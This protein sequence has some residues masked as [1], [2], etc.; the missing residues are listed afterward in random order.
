MEP[1]E[2]V[3]C[4]DDLGYS[5]ARDAG[6][7]RCAEQGL[8]TTASL[9]VT[10]ASARSAAARALRMGLPLGLHLNLTEGCP[11]SRADEVR[12]LL[13]PHHGAASCSDEPPRCA[14]PEL[15]GHGASQR[16]HLVFRGKHGARDAAAAGLLVGAEIERE[17][18]AQIAAFV[19]M[20]GALPLHVDGHQHVHVIPQVAPHFAAAVASAGVRITRLPREDIGCCP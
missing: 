2:L 1:C 18:L 19:A 3:V 9:M 7:F 17:V 16:A 11:V 15:H 12:S 5:D 14:A 8:V 10:G 20:C 13:V 6:I 4:A